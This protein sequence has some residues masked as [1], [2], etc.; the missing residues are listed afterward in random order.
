MLKVAVIN[1]HTPYLYSLAQTRNEF[2]C[3]VNLYGQ[4]WR[5]WDH[6]MRPRPRNVVEL[7]YE[8][9]SP[10]DYDVLVLQTPEHLTSP[11]AKLDLPKI[12][13]QHNLPDPPFAKK[14]FIIS[15]PDFTIVFPSEL[16]KSKWI[17]SSNMVGVAIE[18]GIPDQFYP[19]Q[20]SEKRVLAVV[21]H[22]AERDHVCGFTLWRLLTR[23][24]PNK[25]VG[26]GNPGLGEPA[27]SFEELKLEY[28]RNRVYL[29]TTV[30]YSCMSLRE[31]LMAGMPV[32]TKLEEVPFENEVEIFKSSNLRKLRYYLELCL[33]DYETAR[34]IGEAG[35]K[36]ALELFNIDRFVQK[37]EKLLKEVVA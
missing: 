20:G 21:N 37:W 11:L 3:I 5:H 1:V 12:F 26:H 33:E 24:L 4:P 34:R 17:L 31:A 22:F 7:N 16:V 18:T 28:C 30:S 8:D 23:K 35:R 13:V 19:W 27:K 25:V 32:V 15:S 14:E 9:F 6:A 10:E 2:F 36:K 29:H